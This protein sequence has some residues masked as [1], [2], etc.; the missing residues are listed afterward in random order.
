MPPIP[1]LEALRKTQIM[2]ATILAISIHGYANVTMD[3]ICKASGLSKGGLAHYFKSKT[4][5]FIASFEE[6]FK[7]I[8]ERSRETMARLTDPIEKLLSFDWLYDESDPDGTTGYPILFDCMSIAVHESGAE[9]KRLYHNWV[10]NWIELLQSA[11]EEA[12]AK[13]ILTP[14]DSEATARTI[15]AIYNGIAT[16]WFIDNEAHSSQWAIDSFQ[17]AIKGLLHPYLV[18]PINE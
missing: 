10:E 1:E 6:F 4:E 18:R 17:K 5:L 12:I 9:Y 11:L 2:E 14:L 16:R 13:N 3:E 8:F 15:S 7:R